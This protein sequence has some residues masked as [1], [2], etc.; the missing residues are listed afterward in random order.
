MRSLLL[1]LAIL[2]IYLPVIIAQENTPQ[3]ADFQIADGIPEPLAK[4]IIN[5]PDSTELSIALVN[6]DGT[7]HFYGCRRS[8]ASIEARD[9]RDAL[10]QIGSISKV[11]T[12]TSLAKMVQRDIIALDDPINPFYDF[13]FKDE[14]QITFVELATHSAGLIR[15]P[16]NMQYAN[17]QD[18]FRDYN[19]RLLEGLLEKELLLGEKQYSYSN[20]GA[21]LLGYTLAKIQKSSYS[22]MI[23]NLI[24]G[25]LRLENTGQFPEDLSPSYQVQ[26]RNYQG[27]ATSD[28]SFGALA[29]AGSLYSTTYDLSRFIQ[30][31]FNPQDLALG[32]S[33]KLALEVNDNYSVALGWHILHE[34]GRND[35]WWHNGAVGGF[36]AS[37]AFDPEEQI[38]VVVLSNVSAYY[39]GMGA[40]DALCFELMA[41]QLK[42]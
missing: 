39:E 40:I 29:G 35:W 11:F 25:P 34:E 27:K 15:M 12:A 4:T 26:G 5:L 2:L 1:T 17:Y 41:D 22:E 33:R 23:H 7:I 10:F 16:R 20:L 30:A 14:Q 6:A 38:G 9:N 36:V 32:L 19:G 31:Q 18:P 24:T 3:L 28:W 21:G 8:N 42:E 37:M 13:N